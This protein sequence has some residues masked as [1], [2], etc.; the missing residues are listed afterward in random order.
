MYICMYMC[1]Y[2]CMYTYICVLRTYLRLVLTLF[3]LLLLLLLLSLLLRYLFLL[4]LFMYLASRPLSQHVK[5]ESLNSSILKLQAVKYL[6]V[7]TNYHPCSVTLS[8]FHSGILSN[9]KLNNPLRTIIL[10]F[11]FKYKLRLMK[12]AGCHEQLT[13]YS[14]CNTHCYMY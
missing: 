5:K 6:I 13:T 14:S 11:P 12:A 1:M 9:T 2:I 7:Q 3:S 4:A 10:S 8:L